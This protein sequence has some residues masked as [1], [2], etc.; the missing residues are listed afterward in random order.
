MWMASYLLVPLDPFSNKSGHPDPSDNFLRF[1]NKV[2]N[3]FFGDC[4]RLELYDAMYVHS[5]VFGISRLKQFFGTSGS[6]PGDSGGACFD[7]G[8][9]HCF[10]GMK[11][12]KWTQP[13]TD[14]ISA[15][16]V[17]PDT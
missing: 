8:N 17:H 9:T 11:V 1:P 2:V 6:S 7:K 3:I 14:V 4:R 10:L 16:S 5:C 15:K 13:L 12:G